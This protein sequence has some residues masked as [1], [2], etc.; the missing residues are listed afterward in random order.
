LHA[1]EAATNPIRPYSTLTGFPL[2]AWSDKKVFQ[3]TLTA[4]TTNTRKGGGTSYMSVHY[5]L[6][7]VVIKEEKNAQPIESVMQL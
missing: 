2:A 4:E 3:G 7:E 1:I 6:G 5:I